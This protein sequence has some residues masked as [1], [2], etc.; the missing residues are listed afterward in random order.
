MQTSTELAH[1]EDYH[2]RHADEDAIGRGWKS[3]CVG[4]DDF[5]DS[6]R[7]V[8]WNGVIEPICR[9]CRP[10]DRTCEACGK[11]ECLPGLDGC[12]AC[13]IDGDLHD[14]RAEIARAM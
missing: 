10:F 3:W 5:K 7:D 11:A 13:T 4:C 1:A 8:K 6:T 14:V 2:I 9:D 12:L